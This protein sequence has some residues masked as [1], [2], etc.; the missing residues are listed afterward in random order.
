[1]IDQELPSVKGLNRL[2]AGLRL[3]RVTRSGGGGGAHTPETP[4]TGAGL[5]DDGLPPCDGTAIFSA[6]THCSIWTMGKQT[7]RSTAGGPGEASS[8]SEVGEGRRAP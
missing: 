1:M 6:T 5:T 8:R 4:L 3:S 2:P 7:V